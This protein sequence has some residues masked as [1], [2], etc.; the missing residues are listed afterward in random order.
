MVEI[1]FR[2]CPPTT[3]WRLV[4]R[5]ESSI[6]GWHIQKDLKLYSDPILYWGQQIRLWPL[7]IRKKN[8]QRSRSVPC[9]YKI[10]CIIRI[11]THF[12]PT[13]QITATVCPRRNV[14]YF[15]RVFLMLNYTDITQNTYIQSW[16]VTEIMAREVWNFDSC[17]TLTDYQIH[18][19]TGSNMW[20]L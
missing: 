2:F 11:L 9:L 14:P 16:T 10:P 20:F 8:Y 3:I 15:G 12:L 13:P 5:N 17:Y 1:I 18:I 4:W 6:K 7:E 19:K